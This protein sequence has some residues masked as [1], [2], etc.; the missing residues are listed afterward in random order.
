M[1]K[2]LSVFAFRRNIKKSCR[3]MPKLGMADKCFT[4]TPFFAICKEPLDMVSDIII[5]SNSGVSPTAM[6]IANMKDSRIFSFISAL[7]RKINNT[8][9]MVTFIIR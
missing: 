6:A 5:G 1:L 4:N 8:S 9:A 7:I 2:S 3:E